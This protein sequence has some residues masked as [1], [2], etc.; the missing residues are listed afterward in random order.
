[1]QKVLIADPL[2]EFCDELRSCLQVNYEVYTCTDAE[3]LEDIL[4]GVQPDALVVDLML[5]GKDTLSVLRAAYAA[6]IRPQILAMSCFTSQYVSVV[7]QNLDTAYFLRK[8]CPVQE[9]ATRLV[10]MDRHAQATFDEASAIDSGID[11]ILMSLNF[12]RNRSGWPL[13]VEALRY[14]GNA[15]GRCQM[16]DVYAAVI[17]VYGGSVTKIEKAIR[18]CIIMA[19]KNRNETVWKRYFPIGRD[20]RVPR[21]SV[22]T[23]LNHVAIRIQEEAGVAEALRKAQ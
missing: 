4:Y 10:D 3:T 16:R 12:S 23:F 13:L 19:W 14:M 20:G 8:P 18:D 22:S 2:Q 11:A 15:R 1:M 6:G 5:P 7:L 17:S 21:P 9:V